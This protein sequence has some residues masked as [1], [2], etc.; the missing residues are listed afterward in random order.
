VSTSARKKEDNGFSWGAF[1]SGVLITGNNF[2]V[3]PA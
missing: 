2:C 1:L 3:V